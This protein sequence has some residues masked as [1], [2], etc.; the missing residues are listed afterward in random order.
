MSPCKITRYIPSSSFVDGFILEKIKLL[1]LPNSNFVI[2]LLTILIQ[3]GKGSW[4][5]Y[6]TSHQSFIM[7][8][9]IRWPNNFGDFIEFLLVGSLSWLSK[10]FKH[11]G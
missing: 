3:V 9:L 10:R 11:K 1:F 7:T 5:D 6:Y 2:D 8:F 4:V